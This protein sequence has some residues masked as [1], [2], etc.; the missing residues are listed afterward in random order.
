MPPGP[1]PQLLL[2]EQR[3]VVGLA[4][5]YSVWSGRRAERGRSNT[6]GPASLLFQLS[7][8]ESSCLQVRFLQSWVPVSP[9]SVGTQLIGA[10]SLDNYSR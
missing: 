7:G 9:V 10:T 5:C 3:Y 8:L 1:C 2:R 4:V 6:P